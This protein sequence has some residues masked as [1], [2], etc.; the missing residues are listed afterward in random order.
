MKTFFI[1]VFL[2][3]TLQYTKAQSFLHGVGI[4][5]F[6]TETPLTEIGGFGAITYSPRFN[7]YETEELSLSLGVPLTVGLSGT[8]QYDYYN[9]YVDEQST[10]RFMLNAPLMVN[11]NFGT[12]STKQNQKRFGFFAGGGF[13]MHYGDYQYMVSEN[14]YDYYQSKYGTTVGPAA[15][16]GFRF[17]AGHHQK[18]IEARFSYMKGISTPNT[19]VY[20]AGALFNF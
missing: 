4:G 16:I 17:A 10:I 9:G 13:G 19:A 7:M 14:G 5:V 20:G 12:G 6:V 18:N 11:F 1:S 15:N 8:Y 3:C 2:L